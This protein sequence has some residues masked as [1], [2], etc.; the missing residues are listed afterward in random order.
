MASFQ[1]VKCKNINCELEVKSSRTGY[2]RSCVQKFRKN[3]DPKYCEYCK[4]KLK[5][6]LRFCSKNCYLKSGIKSSPSTRKAQSISHMGLSNHQLG[7]KR[8]S[9]TIEKLKISHL[10]KKHTKETI[11]KIK[12][13]IIKTYNS[14]KGRVWKNRLKQQA[15]KQLIDPDCNFGWGSISK[16]KFVYY[17]E[18]FKKFLLTM[19]AIEDVDFVRNYQVG[20]YYLDFAFVCE[21]R[22]IELDG[23]QHYTT[24]EAIEYDRKRDEYFSLCGWTGMRIPNKKLKR[25]L[26]P[27]WL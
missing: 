17:E 25:F 14:P 4:I 22:Y 13:S 1:F 20:M 18:Y 15:I 26:E 12:Q 7:L 5:D 16:K 2:C 24:S 27:L 3:L 19:G 10:G 9:E 6:W 21:K 8:T 23:Q 11:E